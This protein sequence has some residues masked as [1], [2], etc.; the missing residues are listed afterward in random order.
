MC[1]CSFYFL[2]DKGRLFSF[3]LNSD[4]Q[5][6]DGSQTDTCEPKE[7]SLPFVGDSSDSQNSVRELAVGAH[8]SMALLGTF[9]YDDPGFI[10]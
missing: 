1:F 3:G 8:H 7:I 2:L 4:G 9:R 6:G 5:L 10:M